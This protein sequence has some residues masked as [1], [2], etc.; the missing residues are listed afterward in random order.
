MSEPEPLMLFAS[1]LE[2]GGPDP[3][4]AKFLAVCEQSRA[5]GFV[6]ISMEGFRASNVDLGWLR[7]EID[8]YVSTMPGVMPADVV[9]TITNELPRVVQRLKSCSVDTADWPESLKLAFETKDDNGWYEY[10]LSV[11]LDVAEDDDDQD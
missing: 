8:D 10:S 2:T 7:D 5:E 1:H 3:R 4:Q 6:M 9:E 11:Y